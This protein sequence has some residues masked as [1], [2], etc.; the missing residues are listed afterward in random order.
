MSFQLKLPKFLSPIKEEVIERL[1][2]KPIIIKPV[3][4]PQ[5]VA[6][7]IVQ[8]RDPVLTISKYFKVDL[9]AFEKSGERDAILAS[10]GMG[11]SHL[12]RVIMEETIESN[13]LLIVIDP[14]GEYYTLS[15]RY[16]MLVIG[17]DSA[18]VPL[19]ESKIASYIDTILNEG[20]SAVFDFSD[21]TLDTEQQTMHSVV[22]EALFVAEMKLKEKV[23][24]IIDEA[25]IFAPQN[26]PSKEAKSSLESSVKIAKRGRKHG[27]DSLWSTQRPA[28]LNKNVLSQ[29]NRFWFGGITADTDY[30][31]IKSFLNE[32]GISQEEIKGSKSGDFYYYTTGFLQ[33]IRA[34]DTYTKHIGSTPVRKE[35]QKRADKR[36]IQRILKGLK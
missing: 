26:Q 22:M 33:K 1:P 35:N 18:T 20:I 16:P 3:E 28:S 24:V 27:I 15:N 9:K 17:G 4:P 21:L 2:P 29:C 23:R 25:S 10:S 5:I 30:N 36:D 34:R 8:K 32:A 7:V 14:E 6:P 19:E 13:D 31:A 11:K 12:T